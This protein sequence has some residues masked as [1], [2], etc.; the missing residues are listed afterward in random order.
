MRTGPILLVDDEPVVLQMHA[1]AVQHFGFEAVIA[2]TADEGVQYVRAYQ[3]ALVITDVQ[4]PGEGGFDFVARLERSGL[5]SMPAI[6][7]TGYDDIDIV[8][9]GLRAGGD[10]FIIKGGSIERLRNRIAFWMVGG[11]S[12]LPVDVRRRALTA[13]N[14]VSGDNF[15]NVESHM[16]ISKD[17]QR[18]IAARIKDELSTLPDTYGERLVERICFLGR[19]SKITIEEARGFGDMVR[20]PDYVV[21]VIKS[22]DTPWKKDI[23]SLLMRFDD[24][25]CDTRFVL[26]GVEPLKQFFDYDWYTKGLEEKSNSAGADINLD[27]YMAKKGDG[28]EEFI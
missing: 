27:Q 5:K 28:D 21:G 19:I 12:E 11:F 17:V 4:M 14:T 26:S 24:W 8:R 6:F 13:A 9:S 10:D 22:L 7:L 15:S 2:A 1:A 23:W 18:R 3:P 20:F 16:Q 25:A